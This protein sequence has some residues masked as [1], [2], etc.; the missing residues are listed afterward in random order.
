MAILLVSPRDIFGCALGAFHSFPRCYR[1]AL[2]MRQSHNN[3]SN[4]AF[5][6]IARPQAWSIHG[7]VP[8]KIRK[9]HAKFLKAIE[10]KTEEIVE[11]HKNRKRS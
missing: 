2:E 7:K 9:P 4:C 1:A 8:V 10:A 5:S 3:Y 6:V 11:K